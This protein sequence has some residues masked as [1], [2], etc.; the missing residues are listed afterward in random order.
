MK[1]SLVTS[2]SLP[3]DTALLWKGKRK[4]IMKFAERYLRI[5]MRKQ[6]KR[7]V[8]RSY[9]R[10]LGK[11][12]IIISTRFSSAEYDTF[13]YIAA[14][15]RV[16]VSSLIYGLIKLWQKPSRRAIR[17]FFCINYCSVASKWDSE[18][19]FL[20]EFVTFW[21]SDDGFTKNHPFSRTT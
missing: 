1:K 10:Q 3:A 5:Q 9:N 16:S 19:G 21:F 8:T 6:V 17:R 13:H 7:E 15:L 4:E 18:A 20:E 2:V 11:K 12:F 14:A